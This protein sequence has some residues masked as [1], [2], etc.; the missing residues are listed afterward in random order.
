MADEITNDNVEFIEVN[1]R[2]PV[3]DRLPCRLI[4]ACVML[5]RSRRRRREAGSGG[6]INLFDTRARA[7]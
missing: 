6:T 1:E 3:S 2:V 7:E 4:E 5:G